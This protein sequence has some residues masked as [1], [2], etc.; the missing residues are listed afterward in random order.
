MHRLHII[1]LVHNEA[2]FVAFMLRFLD[3]DFEK[4]SP[5]ETA[6]EWA[7][8]WEDERH[9]AFET[10]KQ[11]RD[12]PAMMRAALSMRASVR[13]W[14]PELFIVFG[15]KELQSIQRKLRAHIDEWIDTGF[16]SDGSEYPAKRNFKPRFRNGND[17]VIASRPKWNSP[18][19]AYDPPPDAIAALAKLHR[20][21]ALPFGL[22]YEI[23]FEKKDSL[24]VQMRI[25][26]RG[27]VDYFLRQE[28]LGSVAELRAAQIFYWFYR[29]SLVFDLM[30][31][32]RCKSLSVPRTKPRKKYER[33][34]H[35]DKCRNGAAAQA[36]TA[37][38]REQFREQWFALAVNAYREYQL[39]PRRATHDLS[40]FVAQQV[41]RGLPFSA[42]IKRNTIT[43][44]L[45]EI[46]A[47]AESKGENR[48]A[49]G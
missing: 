26:S 10:A 42:R 39:K 13:E 18:P 47:Q 6:I 48:N 21:K 17:P 45:K 44:N 22:H 19:E 23:E 24:P 9:T 30:R 15:K 27:G 25:D 43:R 12:I 49:K 31:C 5:K 16:Q 2:D 1:V 37:M 4:N 7:G 20:G 41:N 38:K 40:V 36:A 28:W 14:N 35:C 3:P 8:Q 32:N 29:S 33:G 11:R 46:Q 34:W